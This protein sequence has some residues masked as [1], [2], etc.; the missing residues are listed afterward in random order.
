MPSAWPGVR[1]CYSFFATLEAH[2]PHMSL[3]T[4]DTSLPC[5][6][7]ALLVHVT[8]HVLAI[9]AL[10]SYF[11]S[12]YSRHL[13]WSMCTSRFYRPCWTRIFAGCLSCLRSCTVS[14]GGLS[15]VVFPLPLL[16]RSALLLCL[17]SGLW[18]SIRSLFWSLREVIWRHLMP[19]PALASA[20]DTGQYSP[21]HSPNSYPP[22]IAAVVILSLCVVSFDHMLSHV[23]EPFCVPLSLHCTANCTLCCTPYCTRIVLPIVPSIVPSIVL[24]VVLPIVLSCLFRCYIS[25]Y[26][27]AMFAII[28]L[29]L[30]L[31]T[32]NKCGIQLCILSS[33]PAIYI[34]YLPSICY[35]SQSLYAMFTD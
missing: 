24:S 6:T 17:L 19:P 5:G 22:T 32:T 30:L 9:P 15:L 2:L 11:R 33:R 20:T 12:S 8:F 16:I 23:W 14:E 7:V 10:S 27:S 3:T 1:L 31:Y 21:T 35:Y 18:M 26:T 34:I 29:L 25:L 13:K 4:S 28:S